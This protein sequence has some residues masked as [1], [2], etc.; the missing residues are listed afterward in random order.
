MSEHALRHAAIVT[1]I[2]HVVCL[3]LSGDAFEALDRVSTQALFMLDGQMKQS[4]FLDEAGRPIADVTIARDDDGFIVF[5][6][7]LSVGALRELLAGAECEDLGETY[8]HLSVDGPFAWEVVAAVLGP[9]VIGVPYLSFYRARGVMCFR[10]GKTGEYGYDLLVPR[11]ALTTM[12]CELRER[13]AALGLVAGSREVLARAAIENWFFDIATLAAWRGP[14]L[15]PLELQ[16]RWRLALQRD[17]VGAAALREHTP[18][19]RVTSFTAPSMV[20][21]NDAV[22]FDGERIGAVLVAAPSATRGDVTGWAVLDRAWAHAGIDAYVVDS[23]TGPIAIK[24]RT[25]PLLAN[26]SLFV[27]PHRHSARVPESFPALVPE[28]LR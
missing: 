25:P 20:G 3:R 24:T 23:A 11:D 21:P 6:E 8:A 7:G 2:A 27:D 15:T 13:G 17:F 5:A 19:T 16:L 1:P 22:S 10:A 4:L 26:R 14:T 28:V 12:D 9:E 18:T